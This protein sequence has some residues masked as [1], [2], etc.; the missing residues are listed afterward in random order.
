MAEALD[1]A[2][3]T[4]YRVKQRAEEGLETGPSPGQPAPE[5]HKRQATGSNPVGATNTSPYTIWEA[6]TSSNF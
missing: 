3:S 2:L 5:V 6:S 4:V 1:V